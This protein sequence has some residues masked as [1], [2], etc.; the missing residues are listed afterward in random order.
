MNEKTPITQADEKEEL[1]MHRFKVVFS[2]LLIW[3]IMWFISG[4]DGLSWQ[5][6]FYWKIPTIMGAFLSTLIGVFSFVLNT[7]KQ[8]F[9][10]IYISLFSNLIII[11]SF[12][13]FDDKFNLE[14]NYYL[15]LIPQFI[16]FCICYY[17]INLKK[18]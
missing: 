7:K 5:R 6:A 11:F 10:Q 4:I 12:S 13:F 17:F 8:W 1:L 2:V 15:F 16:Y 3:A 9:S 14:K 18:K